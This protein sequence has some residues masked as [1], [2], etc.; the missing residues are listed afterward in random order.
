MKTKYLLIILSFTL[1][2][3]CFVLNSQTISDL[4]LASPIHLQTNT[5]IQGEDIEVEVTIR[6]NILIPY[7]GDLILSLHNQFNI[8]EDD[9]GNTPIY[10]NGFSNKT[11]T[12]NVSGNLVKWKSGN[13]KLVLKH[14]PNAGSFFTIRPGLYQNPLNITIVKPILTEERFKLGVVLFDRGSNV[15]SDIE[16]MITSIASNKPHREL[17][18]KKLDLVIQLD[19]SWAITEPYENTYN[20]NK[21][22][23][24]AEI[25]K[26]KGIKWTPLLAVHY[27]PNWARN[28]YNNDI[29][30]DPNGNIIPIDDTPFLRF[31]PSSRIWSLETK[32]WIEKFIETLQS[33]IGLDNVIEEILVGNEMMYPAFNIQ[34]ENPYLYSNDVA[35]VNTWEMQHNIDLS[36]FNNVEEIFPQPYTQTTVLQ[37]FRANELSYAIAS[38]TN[39]AMEKLDVLG[40]QKVGVSSK[41]FPYFFPHNEW[42]AYNMMK[43]YTESSLG[44][45][46]ASFRNIFAIDSYP[47]D[48]CSDGNRSLIED[49]EIAVNHPNRSYKRTIKDVYVAEFNRPYLND[50]QN[51]TLTD[52]DVYQA[53]MDGVQYYNVKLFTFYAW[54]SDRLLEDRYDMTEDQKKGMKRAFDAIIPPL[55]STLNSFN[56]KKITDNST[57]DNIEKELTIFPT[58]T[59]NFA[60]V[61]IGKDLLANLELYNIQG[62]VENQIEVLKNPTHTKINVSLLSEGMYLIKVTTIQGKQK[63]LWIVKK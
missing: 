61:N 21:Y 4:K 48:Y 13:Y 22:L 19:V 6:N 57:I 7:S 37:E 10:I 16:A 45:L 17:G 42:S 63:N 38:M 53:V 31:S 54:N 46:D 34:E 47:N 23:E 32:E 14:S 24:I 51:Y 43:G 3:F 50:C 41:L 2:S 27:I 12:F 44:H 59:E 28:K 35:T 56:S 30:R 18:N 39:A 62:K 40:K 9:L 60:Q 1:S 8:P 25:C 36:S 26:R 58:I 52:N 5:I 49:Y 20:F 11:I 55:S 29:L 33:Y 15:E